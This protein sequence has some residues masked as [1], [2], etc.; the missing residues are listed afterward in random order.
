L[1]TTSALAAAR[2]VTVHDARRPECG[3]ELFGVQ[4]LV[5][6]SAA[7]TVGLAVELGQILDALLEHGSQ[8]AQCS[9]LRLLSPHLR[10]LDRLGVGAE[11]PI[12]PAY[13]GC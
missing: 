3:C 7:T 6:R 1:D 9:R 11:A 13:E 10:A 5:G 12:G 8:R 4:R 2:S